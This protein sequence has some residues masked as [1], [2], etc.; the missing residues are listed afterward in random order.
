MKALFYDTYLYR[1]PK[2]VTYERIESSLSQLSEDVQISIHD[3][4]NS[5]K[6][7]QSHTVN[8]IFTAERMRRYENGKQKECYVHVIRLEESGY[9]AIISVY[10]NGAFAEK[11]NSLLD[12]VANT[13][14]TLYIETGASE[15]SCEK[16]WNRYLKDFSHVG[17]YHSNNKFELDGEEYLPIDI[18]TIGTLREMFRDT[19]MQAKSLLTCAFARV[20]AAGSKHEIV[21]L[22]DH[23]CTGKLNRMPVRVRDLTSDIPIKEAA[24]A[25][26]SAFRYSNIS[27]EKAKELTKIDINEYALYSQTVLY[28]KMYENVLKNVAIDRVYKFDALKY[29]DTP[30]FIVFHM[31]SKVASVQYLYD[32]TYFRDFEM[33]GLHNAFKTTLSKLMEYDYTETDYSKFLVKTKSADDKRLD[34]IAGCFKKSGWFNEYSEN[35][36]LKLAEKSS[37]KRMFFEQNFADAGTIDDA[38]YLLV[39]GKVE[40][41]GRDFSNTLHSLKIIKEM[42]FFGLEALSEKNTAVADYEVMTDDA[43]AVVISRDVFLKEAATHNELFVKALTQ[44]NENIVKYQKLWMMS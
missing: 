20:A 21:I 27:Y 44:Q 11:V 41:V 16:Y 43:L 4:M 37:V 13:T 1:Y 30:L 32:K 12:I 17:R 33:S 25:F 36:L 40:V 23:I 31:D 3:I 10:P 2:N 26:A 34:A 14:T 9:I 18:D 42:N 5:S 7:E 15:D 28:D 22:E 6:T 8:G 38:I 29:A 19:P 24:E 35:E 39:H